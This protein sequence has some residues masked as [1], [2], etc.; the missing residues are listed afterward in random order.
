MGLDGK[1]YVHG[2]VVTCAAEGCKASEEGDGFLG[3]RDGEA[4]VV[5]GEFWN[6]GETA[7]KR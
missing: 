3:I 4:E 6:D 1:T 7:G 5:A 2:V